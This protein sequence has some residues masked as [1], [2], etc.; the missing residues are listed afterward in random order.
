MELPKKEEGMV[1]AH[2][3]LGAN[4]PKMLEPAEF[5]DLKRS[6]AEIGTK[7]DEQPKVEAQEP[8]KVL[9][10]ETVMPA[11]YSEKDLEPAT[12]E[13]ESTTEIPATEA[14]VETQPPSAEASVETQHVASSE[15]TEV[16]TEPAREVASGVVTV[17]AEAA[18][19]ET[20]HE[21]VKEA[22]GEMGKSITDGWNEYK[23]TGDRNK[24]VEII[25]K[26]AGQISNRG[27]TLGSVEENQNKFF[28]V[29]T[30]A[31]E[32]LRKSMFNLEIK[33]AEKGLEGKLE[34]KKPSAGFVENNNEGVL[35]KSLEE[36]SDI[37]VDEIG[38]QEEFVS[39]LGEILS[40]RK[41]E[42]IT[43][44]I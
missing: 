24:Q 9:N 21:T 5:E 30:P 23:A 15:G 33:K 16:L 40:H 31:I 43:P 18:T 22:F 28:D 1:F 35:T 13:P 34:I 7:L 26:L 10:L 3:R 32:V 42:T 11:E 36:L 39:D 44:A 8:A 38:L 37:S 4:P 20:N 12:I 25:E 2:E 41:S 17:S 19:P 29:Y 14:S 6:V 27:E